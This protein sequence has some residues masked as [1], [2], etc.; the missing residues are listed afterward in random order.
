MY[1]PPHFAMDDPDEVSAFLRA[2]P[3]ATVVSL[4]D[5]ELVASHVPVLLE[6]DAA[7]GRTLSAHVARANPHWRSWDGSAESLLIFSGPHA[8]VS[9]AWYRETPAVPTWNYAAVH[10]YAYIRAIEEPAA[11][12]PIIDR[13]IG[14]FDTQ[15][16]GPASVPQDYREDMARGTVG[17]EATITRVDAKA[18]LSQNRPV[19]DRRSVVHHLSQSEDAT[20]RSLA[21]LMQ[22]HTGNPEAR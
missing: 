22:A 19:E 9:P 7:T 16:Y 17:F 6:G 10:V 12:L 5:G 8:Y 11:I 4:L 14:V 21:A 15:G 13:L 18:K 1:V 3:F 20:E 2:Y